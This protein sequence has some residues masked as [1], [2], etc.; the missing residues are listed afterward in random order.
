M[1]ADLESVE[2]ERMPVPPLP[3]LKLPLVRGDPAEIV[4]QGELMLKTASR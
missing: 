2:L 3:M 1:V 4:G